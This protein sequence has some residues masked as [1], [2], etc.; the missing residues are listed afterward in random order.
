VTDPTTLPFD[1]PAAP[2]SQPPRRVFTVT[3]LTAAIRTML[4][5][6]YREIWVEG[7][8]SNAR[9]WKT[10]H[11][12][13]TLKDAGA[14]LNAVMFRSTVR[15]LR[16]KPENGQHVVARGRLSVYDRK[17]EYQIVCEHLEPQGIGA[18]QLAFEQLRERLDHE[19]LFA[20]ERKRPLP[21]LPRKI[22]I[23]TSLDG[24]A[25]QDI[26]NVLGRRHPNAHV[27]ISPTRVQ[28]DGAAKEIV[29]GLGHLGRLPGIDVIIVARGGGSME[30][31]WA[32]NEEPVARAIAAAAV[33]VVSGI[34]HETDFTISDFVADLRAPTPSAAAELVVARKDEIAAQIRRAQDRLR[35]AVA[36]DLQQRRTKVH[37][38]EKRPGLAGWP[39]RVAGHGRYSA[40][41]THRLNN[42]VTSTVGR[43]IRELNTVRLRLEALSLGR[44]FGRIRARLVAARTHLAHTTQNAHADRAT[45][46]R[47]AAGR[48]EALSPLAVLSRGYAVCWTADRSVVVRDATAVTPGQSVTVTLHKGELDCEVRSTK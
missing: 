12:Y 2:E 25:V 7:E 34:G 22:G 5:T 32:F 27:I 40:E 44:R 13:F 26:L 33:P 30:D 16:F 36:S 8:I 11:L 45:R 3:A 35:S 9:V 41:L 48:L 15:Y 47:T 31:L 20:T 18:L 28:G 21:A 37:L 6:T 1:D 39:A 46:L 17:G 4:E 24:A 38:L 29:R 10:G 43:Q 14:Q 23:V 42:V 19:G